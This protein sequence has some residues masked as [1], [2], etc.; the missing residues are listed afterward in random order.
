[1]KK[2]LSKARLQLQIENL[3][4]EMWMEKTLRDA[5]RHFRNYNEAAKHAKL[6]IKHGATIIRL[7]K[8]LVQ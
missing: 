8:Q 7:S 2:P 6:A 5:H 4:A 1:M 3:Q